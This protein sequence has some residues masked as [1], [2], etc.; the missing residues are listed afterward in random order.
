MDKRIVFK[1]VDGSVGIIAPSPLFKQEYQLW[2]LNNEKRGITPVL[3]NGAAVSEM[4][5]DK[6]AE[7]VQWKDVPQGL[8]SRIIDVDQLPSDR[9]FR[10]AWT[11]DLPTETVD[12]DYAKAC[13]IKMA[14]IRAKRDE[15]L[16][17]LD[18]ET[19]KGVDVQSE[20]QVLRDLP[21]KV[22]LPE[23]VEELAKFIPEEL[24]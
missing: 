16:A 21:E 18:I 4:D 6:F 10:D 5:A 19:M 1:N 7:F 15:K 13:D 23:T 12:V 11:D 3:W 20:K 9:T 8:D 22:E 17:E 24:A 14:E 2:V